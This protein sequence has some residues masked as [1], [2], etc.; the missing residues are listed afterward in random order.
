MTKARIVI[1]VSILVVCILSFTINQASAAIIQGKIYGSDLELAKKAIVNINS[2]P[3]QNIVA[4]DGTYS[5]IV[6]QGTY[7]IEAVYPIQGVLL[8]A[9][10]TITVSQE[11]NFTIDLILIETPDI[12]DI[13]F[14]ESELKMIEDLLKERQ[15]FDVWYLAGVAAAIIIIAAIL[16]LIYKKKS[17]KKVKTSRAKFRARAV[18]AKFEEEKPIGDEVMAKTLAILKR[19][20]RVTQKDIRKE[21]HISEAKASLVIADLEAQGKVKK[22]KRGRGNVIILT[23]E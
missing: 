12:E 16:Y 20:K 9:N 2:T 10:E 17:K 14:D 15:K 5:F 11:G 6:P 21:L 23:S 3:K 4:E 22:I 7:Q 18:K 13:Q 8:Y 1:M 19:E